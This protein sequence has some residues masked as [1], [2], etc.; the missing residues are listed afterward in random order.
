MNLNNKL[1]NSLKQKLH[2]AKEYIQRLKKDEKTESSCL[3]VC[4]GS[5]KTRKKIAELHDILPDVLLLLS[6]S[7]YQQGVKEDL[8]LKDFTE[9][10]S[11]CHEEIKSLQD[12]KD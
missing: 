4:G 2:K 8:T 6:F 9:F 11:Y 10:I 7:R 12:P 3:D 5:E 1:K